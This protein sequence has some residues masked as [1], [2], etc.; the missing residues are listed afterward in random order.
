[1]IPIEMDSNQILPWGDETHH[2]LF[3]IEY[4]QLRIEHNSDYTVNKTFPSR[5]VTLNVSAASRPGGYDPLSNASIGQ[6]NARAG[7]QVRQAPI[8]DNTN[9]RKDFT[10][11]QFRLARI[12]PGWVVGM[13][14][15][16]S[17][18]RRAGV[19]ISGK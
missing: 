14:E 8:W 13:I 4:G 16:C 11:Q 18:M 17:G 19:Y 12:G 10:E 15:E 7:T 5:R 9:D 1:M 2:G 6:L 3:F